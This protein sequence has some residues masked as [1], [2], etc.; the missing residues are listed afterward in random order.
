MLRENQSFT[1][2]YRDG[3]LLAIIALASIACLVTVTWNLLERSEKNVDELKRIKIVD[4]SDP[5]RAESQ[6]NER[7]SMAAETKAIAEYDPRAK[8]LVFRL[9]H[10]LMKDWPI[11]EK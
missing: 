1:S 6:A 4:V 11:C 7:E 5:A 10:S 9:W 2:R 3:F 8:K